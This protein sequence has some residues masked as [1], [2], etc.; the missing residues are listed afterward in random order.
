MVGGAQN[1]FE[2]KYPQTVKLT[3]LFEIK[4]ISI[5]VVAGREMVILKVP[6]KAIIEQ[7]SN[8]FVLIRVLNPPGLRI[9]P[10][11]HFK[12]GMQRAEGPTYNSATS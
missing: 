3:R 5:F 8:I 9:E 11:N 1:R 12:P 7:S 4:V 2:T 10:G 6:K